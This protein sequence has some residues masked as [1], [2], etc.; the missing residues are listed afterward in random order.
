M[1][2]LTGFSSGYEL[3]VYLGEISDLTI[4]IHTSL[5]REPEAGVYT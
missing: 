1:L 4:R 3:K 2:N 5:R